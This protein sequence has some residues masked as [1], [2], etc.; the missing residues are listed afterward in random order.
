VANV[1]GLEA[2]DGAM[3]DALALVQSEPTGAVGS[4]GH[5]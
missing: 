5:G 3:L 1:Y 4:R 2:L